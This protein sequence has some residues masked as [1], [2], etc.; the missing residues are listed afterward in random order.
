MVSASASHTLPAALRDFFLARNRVELERSFR[1]L[2][3]DLGKNA[4]AVQ[5]WQEVEFAFNRLFVGPAALEAPPYASAYLEPQALVMGGT[6]LEVRSMFAAV[7]LES[8]WK[9]TLPDD[10]ISLELDGALA[11]QHAV[12]Q[13]DAPQLVDLHDRYLVHMKAWMPQFI[14]RAKT[15]PSRHPAIVYAAECLSGW[16]ENLAGIGQHRKEKR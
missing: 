12:A 16:L 10:H 2:P 3:E 13:S 15:A 8:P 14:E 9:N 4:P 5:D 1:D 7:G 6:T 11:M